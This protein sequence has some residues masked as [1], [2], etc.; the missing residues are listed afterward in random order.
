[1]GSIWQGVAARDRV[2]GTAGEMTD[3]PIE[4]FCDEGFARVR[5]AFEENFAL[6]L[7]LGACFALAVEGE[8]VVDLWAGY[9]DPQR[10][11]RWQEDTIAP[12]YSSAKIPLALCGLM[13]L[14]R[15]LIELDAPV[16]RY[17]PEFA[18]AGKSEVLVRHIFC[19]SSGVGGFDPPYSW[20]I[21]TDWDDAVAQLASQA[22]WW[23]PGTQTRY[24]GVTFHYLI[25]ELIL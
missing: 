15:G 6:D 22:P 4:G 18:A 5:A 8:L 24:H 10:T 19:H 2:W 14:D 1:M 3:I 17:W 21:V 12:I 23:E 20:S 7:E 16:A 11:R 13:I 9:A 25:G